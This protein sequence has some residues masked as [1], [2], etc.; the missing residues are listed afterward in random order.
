MISI[1][2]KPSPLLHEYEFLLQLWSK[3]N[4]ARKQTHENRHLLVDLHWCNY[5]NS[6]LSPCPSN[7]YTLQYQFHSLEHC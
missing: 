3:S 6:E 7:L 5:Y 2:C 4:L 1:V